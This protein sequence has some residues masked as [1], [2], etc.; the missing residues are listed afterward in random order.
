MIRTM[1]AYCGDRI[2]T[3]K[4]H[5][6]PRCL[7]PESRTHSRVQRLTIPSCRI[8]NS[9]WSDDEVH[10]RNMLMLAGEQP[11]ASRQELWDTTVQRSFRQ[12][13][14]Y[15]RLRHLTDAMR[16]VVID[17]KLRHKVYPGKDPRVVRIVKK[18]VRGLSHY[19]DILSAV[20][21]SRV[22][23]NV[24][25]YKMPEKFL[26]EMTYAHREQDIVEYRYSIL[27]YDG[28]QSAWL[29][30]FFE[31]VTF[32]GMVSAAKDGFLEEGG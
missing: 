2:A 31:M 19:H 17:G 22:W 8:C 3:D 10:F 12:P 4:E 32:I 1:C 5:V 23:V 6:F 7:Y 11:N 27:D 21:E 18:V 29:I 26:D 15:R 14:A 24:M 28:I 20:P 25:I 13:D 30:T 9:D 16:P